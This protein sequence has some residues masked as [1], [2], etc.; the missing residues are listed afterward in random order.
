MRPAKSLGHR[1]RRRASQNAVV[2]PP[3]ILLP[4]FFCTRALLHT[5]QVPA[6]AHGRAAGALAADRAARARRRCETITRPAAP[7]VALFRPDSP[8]HSAPAAHNNNKQTRAR[9]CASCPTRQRRQSARRGGGR[10]K[11]VVRRRRR[12]KQGLPP[13]QQIAA[14]LSPA[15]NKRRARKEFDAMHAHH[16]AHSAA[17]CVRFGDERELLLA[18]AFSKTGALIDPPPPP[19]PPPK[20]KEVLALQ[21]QRKGPLSF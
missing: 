15:K 11:S 8:A 20:E 4:R 19:P 3:I 18:P 17:V 9:R 7:R 14:R 10:G 1:R 21:A 13:H 5:P 16:L 6:R 12:E 2:L